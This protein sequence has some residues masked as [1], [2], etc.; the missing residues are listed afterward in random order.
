M[1]LDR[2]TCL[3]EILPR[4]SYI[5]L[6]LGSATH[7]G[8]SAAGTA[9]RVEVTDRVISLWRG[10]APGPPRQPRGSLSASAAP[11]QELTDA[12]RVVETAG[13][14]PPPLSPCSA[15]YPGRSHF[16]TAPSSF[17]GTRWFPGTA[18]PL[19]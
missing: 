9:L 14:P 17:L 5:R 6:W 19:V 11:R 4:I 12:C 3:A 1:V 10:R 16:S 8:R 7:D 2:T 13:R 15:G 18:I